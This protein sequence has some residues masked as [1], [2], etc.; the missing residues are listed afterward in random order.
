MTLSLT[1][2]NLNTMTNTLILEGGQG[3]DRISDTAVHSN[4]SVGQI[5]ILEDTVFGEAFI[6]TLQKDGTFSV[7]VNVVGT[8]D[9][10]GLGGGH[11]AGEYI[12]LVSGQERLSQIRLISGAI[13]TYKF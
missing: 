1:L 2:L 10:P 11:K 8:T 3:S 6:Q 5:E 4:L 13:R 7:G 9:P 12:S